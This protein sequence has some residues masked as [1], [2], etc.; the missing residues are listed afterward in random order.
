M[1]DGEPLVDSL[2]QVFAV[3]EAEEDE[4]DPTIIGGPI[5]DGWELLSLD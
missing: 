5:M 3:K 2:I 4:D 1:A